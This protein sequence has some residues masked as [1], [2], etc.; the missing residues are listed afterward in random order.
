MKPCRI[1][2]VSD[3]C[4]VYFKEVIT[5]LRVISISMLPCP[6]NIG[7]RSSARSSK[8]ENR[9]DGAD[10]DMRACLVVAWTEDLVYSL[11]AAVIEIR[12]MVAD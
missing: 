2:N 7:G 8:A 4:H 9:E 10:V 6:C 12:L 11:V 3:T 1:R 5:C